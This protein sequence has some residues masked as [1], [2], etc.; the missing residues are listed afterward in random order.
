MKISDKKPDC[1]IVMIF[2]ILTLI[3]ATPL[4]WLGTS[5]D[6]IT[7]S[8]VE[9]RNLDDFPVFGLSRIKT[10]VKHILLGN[11]R[12]A[13]QTVFSDFTN[14]EFQSD[15][16]MA[17]AD[18]F[19]L[20]LSFI[21]LARW[22]ER[23]QVKAVYSF[24][25][26]PA[27]PASLNDNTY[28][29]R[30]EPVYIQPPLS[31]NGEFKEI[32]D[33][34]IDNYQNL[35]DQ[36]PEIHF[37]VFYLERMAFAPYNPMADYYS[38]A[39]NGQSFNYFLTHKPDELIVSSM[40]LTDLEEHKE[41]FF[42]TDHHWNI[43]GAWN[44]YEI[45]YDMLSDFTPDLSPMLDLD[46]FVE[47]EG[48]E[49]CGSYA[50][51]TLYPCTPEKFEYASVKLPEYKTII[52]GEETEYGEASQYLAGNFSLERY[53]NHYAE[54]FGYVTPL[55]D[56]QFENESDRNLL[57]IGGSYTQAMQVYVAS[58]Y[59]RTLVV[60]LREYQDF[61]LSHFIEQYNIDDILILGDVIVYRREGWEIN[62]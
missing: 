20:R 25:P 59:R 23:S 24:L 22:I 44:A 7:F 13:Y 8:E 34:R 3:F 60:D 48:V 21:S 4:Y 9:N 16:E 27:F 29:M 62:P 19:P 32:V 52:D 2:I 1:R 10:A 17:A 43:R 53:T 14:N 11:I 12:S 36:F 5:R 18:Y 55:V 56:Y 61:S 57:I 28:L 50:R 33:Q 26:D 30:D 31:W 42:W 49:Y 6:N 47:I 37:Y 39:D 41:K 45:I 38:S 46:G 54:F 58:H 35:I 40:R 15:F 51:R